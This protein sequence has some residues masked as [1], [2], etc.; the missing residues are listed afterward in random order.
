M[1]TIRN[2]LP[3]RLPALSCPSAV[4]MYQAYWG[5]KDSPFRGALDPRRFYAGATQDEALARLYF[6]VDE[7]RPLGLLLGD[8][9][10]GKTLLLDVFARQLGLV[11]RQ[12][13]RISLLGIDVHELLWTL[14]AQLG[15]SVRS[16]MPQ[17]TLTRHID[18]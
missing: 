2:W 18:D 4:A 16:E 5:L 13:A 7:H 6:L 17:F 3:L 14:G 11:N 8:P 1:T 12:T 10:S 15:A 9:G